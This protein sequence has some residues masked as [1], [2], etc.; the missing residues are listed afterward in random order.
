MGPLGPLKS[1]EPLSAK[2]P[3]PGCIAHVPGAL[4]LRLPSSKHKYPDTLATPPLHSSTTR[5]TGT[6]QCSR[7]RRQTHNALPLPPRTPRPD[8]RTS[9]A[10][11]A[12]EADRNGEGSVLREDGPQEGAMDAGGG[13]GPRRPHPALRPRQLARPAQASR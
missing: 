2:P 4:L 13:Q 9:T 1:K 11:Q 3:W 8:K 7:P 6:R 5:T 10:P 12:T